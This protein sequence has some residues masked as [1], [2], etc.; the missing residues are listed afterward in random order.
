VTAVLAFT[1][2]DGLI[3]EVDILT[4]PQRLAAL[5]LSL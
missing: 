5:N 2:A 1:V 3:V 4:D